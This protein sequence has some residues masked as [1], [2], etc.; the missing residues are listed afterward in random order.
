MVKLC[1][2]DIKNVGFEILTAVVM[3]SF[4]FWD[5]KLRQKCFRLCI[6]ASRGPLQKRTYCVSKGIGL[7]MRYVG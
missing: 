1:R 3:K 5:I 2:E 4:V 6:F 7:P